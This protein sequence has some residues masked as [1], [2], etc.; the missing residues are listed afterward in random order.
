MMIICNKLKLN[1]GN[2]KQINIK[3]KYKLINIS[4]NNLS[5]INNLFLT[6]IISF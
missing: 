4:I 6:N 3:V 5:F 2:N 1:E